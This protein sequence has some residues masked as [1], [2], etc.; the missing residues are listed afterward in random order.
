MLIHAH[1]KC[2]VYLYTMQ[3]GKT[4]FPLSYIHIM[5]ENVL[6]LT[7]SLV[8]TTNI[9]VHDLIQIYIKITRQPGDLRRYSLINI[10]TVFVCAGIK[11]KL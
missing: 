10:V 2:A 8:P 3:K 7:I 6:N 11:I 4:F 5:I 9:V 1:C